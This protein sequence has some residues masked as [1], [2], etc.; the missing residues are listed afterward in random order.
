[1][2]YLNT[3]TNGDIL[4]I[5]LI[6]FAC[7]LIFPRLI[8]M[9]R[10]KKEIYHKIRCGETIAPEDLSEKQKPFHTHNGTS[11]E[12][13][14]LL[15]K[16]KSHAFKHG[17]KIIFPGSYQYKDTISPTTMILAGSFGLLLI[18]CYGFGGHVYT[19]GSPVR[20]V[21]DMNQS[22]KEIPNPEDSM[23]QEK[24]LME[25]ALMDSPYENIPIYAASVFTR[26]NLILS[27]PKD[28]LV[29]NRSGFM[30]WLK[31]EPDFQA[32]NQVPVKEIS[33]Y[34]VGMVK[35]KAASAST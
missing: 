3:L 29:F 18:H 30:E 27:V 25:S 26:H 12:I 9:R 5:C 28:C 16:L 21:Q 20:W 4:T 6:I 23:E 19:K 11:K 33:D 24:R 2:D 17:M 8:R 15:V 7:I 10:I 35:A 1:M 13:E 34:L 22:I 31:T 14:E 32:D